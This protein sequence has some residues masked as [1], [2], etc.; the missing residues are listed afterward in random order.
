MYN[1]HIGPK[2]LG[3]RWL[4]RFLNFGIT[5]NV[6]RQCGKVQ[7]LTSHLDG[8]VKNELSYYNVC[9]SWGVI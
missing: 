3:A 8:R 7:T 5:Y 9:M 4:V 6:G 2:T 1:V